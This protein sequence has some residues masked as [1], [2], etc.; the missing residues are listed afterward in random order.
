MKKV[1]LFDFFGV[2]CSEIAPFWFGS[3]FDEQTAKVIKEE[4]VGPADR[5]YIDEDEMFSKIAARCDVRADVIR[6]EW[7]EMAIVDGRMVE[8]ILELKKEYKIFLLS[9]APGSFLHDILLK[10]DLYPLFDRMFISSEIRLAKPSEGYFKY[11]IKE[12]GAPTEDLI[13]TDD[14]PANVEAAKAVGIDAICF[15]GYEDFKT[16][17]SAILK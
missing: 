16:K 7:Q 17:L 13:F 15:V 2:I 4:L 12:I 9:N 1:I 6:K 3:R 10:N 8:L 11:C 5:G 14:N